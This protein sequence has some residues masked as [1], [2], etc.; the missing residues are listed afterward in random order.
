MKLAI[1][2]MAISAGTGKMAMGSIYGQMETSTKDN[3]A[4]I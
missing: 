2:I 1:N 4:K 3:F